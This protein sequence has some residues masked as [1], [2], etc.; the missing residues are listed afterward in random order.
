M[1]FES[2]L[3]Q[4]QVIDNDQLCKIFTCSPQGGMR[5]SL[6]TNTLVLISNHVD[7]IY[8]DR[9]IGNVFHYTGMGQNGDQSLTFNQNKT[10][11]A[12]RTN[13]VE[14]HLFEVNKEKEYTYQGRVTLSGDPYQEIQPDQDKIDRKVY[15]FPVTLEGS[16]PAPVKNTEFFKA[17]S[18]REKKAK[19]LSDEE[20]LQK[21]SKAP[22]I[23][24]ERT[25]TGTQYERDPYVSRL[26]KRRA[27]GICELCEEP[28][29]FTDPKGESY[30]E[31]H[32]VQWLSRGGED[33]LANTV[34]LCPNCH[35][36]MHVLDSESD[37]S[38]LK[39]KLRA[40]D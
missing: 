3:T 2:G 23:A 14:V 20:L 18:I 17:Q 4:G 29:P 19:K 6:K 5:R 28:A 34:A 12:S 31:I 33:S 26:T 22:K 40:V 13:G 10:L 30:L 8:D 25:V 35:R 7:S 24:G 38:K 15:V 27:K 16:S 36:R 9:W 21:A 32:H 39:A 37:K 11:A 1:T